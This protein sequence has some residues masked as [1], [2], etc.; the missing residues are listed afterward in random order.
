LATDLLR[1]PNAT[2]SVVGWQVGDRSAV[3]PNTA[4]KRVRDV[5]LAQHRVGATTPQEATNDNDQ[6]RT[7]R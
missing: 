6:R 4:F 3:A 7:P 5:S 2:G 1:E